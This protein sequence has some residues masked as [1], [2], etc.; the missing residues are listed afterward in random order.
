MTPLERRVALAF[1]AGLAAPA[2]ARLLRISVGHAQRIAVRMAQS[3]EYRACPVAGA[4]WW[5]LLSTVGQ[6][7]LYAI[8][9]DKLRAGNQ[10]LWRWSA[11]SLCW[12]RSILPDFRQLSVPITLVVT[13]FLSGLER[14]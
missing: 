13:F 10:A 4:A 12:R 1:R 5:S 2:I 7:D 3:D 9:P 11:S 6:C 8:G 14:L